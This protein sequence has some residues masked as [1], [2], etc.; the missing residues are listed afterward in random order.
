MRL[1]SRELDPLDAPAEAESVWRALAEAAPP[2]YFL[3]W[4]WVENWLA[5][6]PR[7]VSLRLLVVSDGDA[8]VL[9]CFIGRRTVRRAGFVISRAL[10]LN[11]T[12]YPDLDDIVIE[13]NGWLARASDRWPLSRLLEHL[14]EGGWDELVLDAMEGDALAGASVARPRKLRVKRAAPCPVVELDRVRAAGGG[15]LSLLGAQTRSQIRRASRL[16]QERGPIRV[17]AATSLGEARAVFREL[18]SLHQA[19]WSK[20]GTPGAFTQRYLRDF[21]ERLIDKRFEHGE[22]QLLRVHAGDRTIGCL[23]NFAWNGTVS[24]YQSGLAY[25]DDN[26]LKPGLVCHAEAVAH[27]AERGFSL[28]DLL[29]GDTRYKR[30]LSTASSELVWATVQQRRPQFFVEDKL[31]AMRDRWRTLRAKV[32]AARRDA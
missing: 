22:I 26:R 25:E 23:Y 6:L 2:T 1:S 21:H 11:A 30:S 29:G 4:P 28:Y 10:Y 18:V 9:A 17:D 8:P 7:Y 3:A 12:G 14:P 16:Y 31:R 20:K 27:N 19:S 13:H 32:G 5:T 15:Y 24:F